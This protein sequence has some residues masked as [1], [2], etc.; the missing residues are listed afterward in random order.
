MLILNFTFK[1]YRSFRDQ[2]QFSMQRD[3]EKSPGGWAHPD[4][5]TVCAIYGPNAS[6][7]STLLEAFEYMS[8]LVSESY[9]RGDRTS[10]IDIDPFLL[11]AE[12]R[13]A[14]S[15][16]FIEFIANNNLRYKYWFS[17]DA[18]K[19]LEESLTVYRSSRPT[20]LFNRFIDDS[21]EAD[22][23]FGP[24]FSGPKQQLW[25][26]TRPNSLFLSA[27][28][29]SAVDASSSIDSFSAFEAL[30][31]GIGF[32]SAPKYGM[33]LTYIKHLL[34]NK[35]KFGKALSNM[36]S[37]VDVGVNGI[38]LK[39]REPDENIKKGIEGLK[40][41]PK[42]EKTTLDLIISEVSNT[43]AF[44]HSG[45][46]GI[47]VWLESSLE[48]AGTVAALS[49][50]S[51]ALQTLSSGSVALVDELDSSLHPVLVDELVR[52]FADPETNPRQAQ[53]IF[54][55]HDVS[56]ITKSGRDGRAI[57]RDQLWFVEK[58]N[59]GASD[60]YPVTSMP[61]RPDE[62]MGRNYMLGVYGALPNIGLHDAVAKVINSLIGLDESD[63][64]DDSGEFDE[65]DGVE[66]DGA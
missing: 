23:K 62:N 19:V 43:L 54:T 49:F 17:I 60:L 11:D 28:G 2:T 36:I 39:E 44:G 47:V 31:K 20:V 30:S 9:A 1:N 8:H 16:F 21:G 59:D 14:P 25:K 57:Q 66:K 24:S 48:S 6:G 52:I 7:K 46:D 34:K 15:E 4:V 50:L 41:D 38:S 42:I 58:G 61:V 64:S 55:T 40:E 26:L 65:T 12:S 10:G 3:Q 45:K 22:I 63:G 37:H 18:H 5:S 13:S 32:Y 53:L 27:V 35:S 56:L 29:A 51:V 33:E